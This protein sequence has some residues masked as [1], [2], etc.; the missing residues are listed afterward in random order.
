MY[1]IYYI[2]IHTLHV[3]EYACRCTSVHAV[4]IASYAH[5]CDLIV[6]FHVN[7]EKDPKGVAENP[8]RNRPPRNHGLV[9]DLVISGNPLFGWEG[10]LHFSLS[11][12][13][14]DDFGM[15]TS[16]ASLAVQPPVCLFPQ[17]QIVASVL[18]QSDTQAVTELGEEPQKNPTGLVT[19]FPEH[20]GPIHLKQCH[21]MSYSLILA[22]IHY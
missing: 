13:I 5:S 16:L 6:R 8:A 11:R 15:T 1:Y 18:A 2:D 3:I 9:L 20:V 19:F 21:D 17:E 7:S 10:V 12:R 14:L 22:I 4:L